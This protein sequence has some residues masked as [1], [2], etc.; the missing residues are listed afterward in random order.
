MDNSGEQLCRACGLCCDGSFFDSVRLGPGDARAKL[1]ALGLP[2]EVAPTPEPVAYFCQPCTALCA[3]RT[4]RVY[5]DRPGQC[6]SF[7]CG[8]F[9]AVQAGRIG[10]A[11]AVRLVQQAR[12]R[13]DAVRRLLRKLGDTGEQR[14]L[15]ERFRRVQRRMDTGDAG[16]AAARTY[17]ELGVAMHRLNLLA[18]E[19]FHTRIGAPDSGA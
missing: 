1:K 6:R 13:A 10:F 18:Y 17:A 7:E 9:K 3:D 16:E 8:V 12:R 19:K 14:P 2:V 15:G 5:A 11:E 4:C